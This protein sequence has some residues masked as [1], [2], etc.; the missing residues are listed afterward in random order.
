MPTVVF[1]QTINRYIYTLT[2]NDS[3]NFNQGEEYNSIISVKVTGGTVALHVTG[4]PE[5]PLRVITS[6]DKF[7][8]KAPNF[9]MTL[10]T[11]VATVFIDRKR[12]RYDG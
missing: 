6:T 4:L 2:G 11:G 5:S 12:V 9:T 1:D 10:N 8:C 3:F 7:G